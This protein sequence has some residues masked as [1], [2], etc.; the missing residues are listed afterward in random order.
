[1]KLKSMGENLEEIRELLTKIGTD[2]QQGAFEMLID[3]YIPYWETLE[4][5][6]GEF[7]SSVRMSQLKLDDQLTYV[8]GRQL[9]EHEK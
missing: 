4:D 2:E 9:N 8:Y 3:I 1:M 6:M 7:T 5:D